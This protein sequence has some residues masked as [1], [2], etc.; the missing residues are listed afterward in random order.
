MF[1]SPIV[2]KII[3]KSFTSLFTTLFKNLKGMI[4]MEHLLRQLLLRC[5]LHEF[6]Y[7]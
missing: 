7:D 5:V 4:P 1:M 3:Y 6:D 2:S